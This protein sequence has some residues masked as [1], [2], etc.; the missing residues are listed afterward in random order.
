MVDRY[1]SARNRGKRGKRQRNEKWNWKAGLL[2]KEKGAFLGDVENLLHHWD[3][4]HKKK[5][6][7]TVFCCWCII[8]YHRS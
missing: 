5:S 8:Q 3:Q 1:Y 4:G 7:K 6:L 2:E